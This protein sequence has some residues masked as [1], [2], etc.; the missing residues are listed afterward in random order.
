MLVDMDNNT[1]LI[2]AMRELIA[3]GEAVGLQLRLLGGL[4]VRLRCPTAQQPPFARNYGDADC[5]AMH[6]PAI[7]QRFFTSRGWQPDREFNTYNGDHRLIFIAP[8]GTKVDVFVGGFRMCHHFRFERRIPPTGLTVYPAELLL[9]KL[10]IHE[11]NYKDLADAACILLDYDLTDDDGG[12][13][14]HYIAGLCADDWGLHRS[15]T[16]NLDSTVRWAEAYVQDH[17][18]IVRITEQVDQL[19][20]LMAG[21]PKTLRWQARALLGPHLRWYEVV[22]EVER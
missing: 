1:A 2:D 8:A 9:T 3:A 18:K 10:Q 6:E 5:L 19:K 21:L 16:T 17:A 11:V 13:H 12:I 20:Q 7:L 4:G 14:G 22:E 15:L